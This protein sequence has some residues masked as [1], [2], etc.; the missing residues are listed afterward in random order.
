MKIFNSS[1]FTTSIVLGLMSI[2]LLSCSNNEVV[3]NEN[4][5]GEAAEET[6]EVQEET[7]DEVSEEIEIL[8]ENIGELIEPSII[9]D[10]ITEKIIPVYGYYQLVEKTGTVFIEEYMDEPTEEV[11]TVLHTAEV[12][13]ELSFDSLALS[14]IDLNN[15]LIEEEF[16][17]NVSS[18]FRIHEYTVIQCLTKRNEYNN[19]DWVFIFSN[20]EMVWK[21]VSRHYDSCEDDFADI[22]GVVSIADEAFLIIAHVMNGISF[23][24][25]GE[26]FLEETTHDKEYDPN[27]DYGL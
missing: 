15:L 3:E 4:S 6:T 24:Q 9:Q 8:E 21:T 7:L 19:S 13:D 16:L 23:V 22:T 25:I 10:G 26:G 2:S 1:K 14:E 5:L 20:G 27:L 17:L 11:Y 12:L 18:C